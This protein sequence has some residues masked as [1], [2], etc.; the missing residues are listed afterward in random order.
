M[1]VTVKNLGILKEAEFDVGD[2]TIICGANNTGKTY[3]TY[4][5]YGFL[6]FFNE[7][8]IPRLLKKEDAER[9]LNNGSIKIAIDDANEL[10]N[11]ACDEYSR[12]L[13][14]VFAA[15]DKYFENAAFRVSL[16]ET[17]MNFAGIE[18]TI[19]FAGL[20][21]KP[22]LNLIK[23]RGEHFITINIIAQAEEIDMIDNDWIVQL[24]NRR[25]RDTLFGNVLPAPFIASIER[26]G[27]ALFQRELD[28]SR[29]RLLEH[30]SNR[31]KDIDPHSLINAYYDKRYALPV[32]DDV[33]FN[34]SLLD[35]VKFEGIVAK[36]NPDILAALDLILGG[37]Y[38]VAKEGLYYIPNKIKVKLTMGESASSVR[39]L[40]NFGIYLRHIA[41]PGDILMIDEPELNLHPMNQRRMA[42]ILAKLVNA[43]IKV[44][45]TTHSDYILKEFNTLIMLKNLLNS[46]DS[47]ASRVMEK[48]QYQDNELL[49]MSRIKVYIAK[50][51]LIKIEGASR[52]Q[53]HNTLVPAQ[54]DEYGIGISDFDDT[55]NEMNIIQDELFFGGNFI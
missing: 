20:N 5:L 41:G 12:N 11:N 1:K 24:I 31:D 46:P 3:A 48:Y 32:K 17:D 45:I 38:K 40:L 37:E 43:G 47:T 29:N 28:F 6:S 22:I 2:L 23:R 26:T 9:L 36:N 15:H 27:A 53:K 8:F 10:I 54:I 13:S 33:D 21:R 7:A 18:K 50:E 35:V 39:S 52:R 25:I 4:A 44:F 19:Q 42:R 51:K 16:S 34:R 55:I 49:D 14:L 30:V